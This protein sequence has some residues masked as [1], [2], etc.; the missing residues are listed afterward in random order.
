M[1]LFMVSEIRR[2]SASTCSSLT[3]KC[4]VT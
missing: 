1:D 3:A 2:Q 4:T